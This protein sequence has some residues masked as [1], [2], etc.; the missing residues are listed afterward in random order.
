MNWGDIGGWVA[1]AVAFITAV[2]V[3]GQ[4]SQKVSDHSQDIRDLWKAK[5]NHDD[6]LSKHGERIS[7]LE[8]RHGGDE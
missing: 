7:R 5:V 8:G 6:R 1:A 2:F 4:L 3:Y